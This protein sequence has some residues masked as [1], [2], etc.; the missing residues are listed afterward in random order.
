MAAGFRTYTNGGATVQLSDDEIFYSLF[1][2]GSELDSS[3]WSQEGGG[4]A[5]N[6][7][8]VVISGY[9]LSDEPIMALRS[10][11]GGTWATLID[12]AN[13]D[14]T[15]RIFRS[16]TG[17]DVQWFLFAGKAPPAVISGAGLHL[18]NSTGRRVFSS[19]SPPIRVLGVF[20]HAGY[21]GQS[22]TGLALAHAPMKSKRES[23]TIYSYG[24][25][26][27]CQVGGQQGY[28]EFIQEQFARSAIAVGSGVAE[29]NRTGDFTTRTG[30][31]V[32]TANPRSFGL[33]A[34]EFRTLVIDVTN[35]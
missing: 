28:E 17:F 14:L 7:R 30:A 13:G 27:S 29:E 1:E 34:S 18:Y 5:A 21:V 11:S 4:S 33:D 19:D 12:T 15:Y 9:A 10:A 35:L 8:D 6:F 2:Q 16:S 3:N 26:G 20:S 22:T 25:L 31:C 32:T 24:G 23:V